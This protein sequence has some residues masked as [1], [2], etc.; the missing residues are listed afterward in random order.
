M[1]PHDIFVVVPFLVSIVGANLIFASNEIKSAAHFVSFLFA[2]M[3]NW[4]LQESHTRLQITGGSV[5]FNLLIIS[6]KTPLTFPSS[7]EQDN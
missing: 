7:V 4:V 5:Q 2:L 6:F 1:L 3:I